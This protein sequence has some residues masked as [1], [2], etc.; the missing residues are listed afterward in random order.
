MRPRKALSQAFLDDQRVARAIVRAA[1]V[2]RASDAVLEVGPGLGVL[3]ERLVANARQ[4]V[5]IELDQHLAE[6]LRAI[7]AD[8]LHVVTADVLATNIDGLIEEPFVVVANLPYHI[9]SPALRHLLASKARRLVVMVQ[10]EVAERIA[11]APGAMSSLAVTVQVQARPTIVLRVPASAFYPPPRVD[12]AVLVLEPLAQPP[13]SREQLPR[14]VELVQA[15]FKQPR[16]QLGN[17]LAEGLNID[18]AAAARRLSQAGIDPGRRPQELAVADWV[19]LFE[20]T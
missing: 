5:A 10:R 13:V 17:S 12:S 2:D 1:A 6:A 14:F 3:T 16:K 11:A 18:K 19:R 4:V 8:N 20:R 7:P 9:T 15:G